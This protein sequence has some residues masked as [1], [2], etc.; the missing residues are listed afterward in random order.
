MSQE[1]FGFEE[2]LSKLK[3]GKLVKRPCW[4]SDHHLFLV[5]GSIFQ[6]NRPPLLGILAEGTE[7]KYHA[8]IDKRVSD[9][10]VEPWTA[11]QSDLLEEWVEVDNTL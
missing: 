6:V 9:N 1:I 10:K 2:A 11:S 4:P 7:V 5:P 3:Q 8:H